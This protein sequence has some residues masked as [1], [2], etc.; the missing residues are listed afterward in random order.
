MLHSLPIGGARCRKDRYDPR[1]VGRTVRDLPM[2]SPGAR[3]PR[4]RRSR[5]GVRRR[6]GRCGNRLYPISPNHR[7]SC[8]PWRV[9]VL[10][11]AG[12]VF[13]CRKCYGLA[14]ASQQGGLLFRN[15][16]KSQGIRMRL[17][18]SPDPFAPF[19]A[20]PRRMHRRTYRR[21][22]AQARDGEALTF[23]RR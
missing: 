16:R 15:L 2:C 7:H 22:R 4:L 5:A 12:E 19:P 10:Y 14:Y 18:G 9:A 6:P 1:M 8:L 20:K 3:R 21:L 23:G 13:A 17:G 11:L